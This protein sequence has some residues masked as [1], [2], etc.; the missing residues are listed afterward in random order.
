MGDLTW[1]AS[2]NT[3]INLS[4]KWSTNPL[5]VNGLCLHFVS[6]FRWSSLCGEL[7]DPLWDPVVSQLA[8]GLLLV[9]RVFKSSSH[10]SIRN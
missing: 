3:E 6:I 10:L 2:L 5:F 4:L 1:L 9:K 7:C 8:M